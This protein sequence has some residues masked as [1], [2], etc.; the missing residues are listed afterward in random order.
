MATPTGTVVKVR[1]PRGVKEFTISD[2]RP[3][4]YYD[5]VTVAKNIK[6]QTLELFQKTGGSDVLRNIQMPGTI[7]AGWVFEL[8]EIRISAVG[9]AA[10]ADLDKILKNSVLSYLHSSDEIF[11]KPLY[12]FSTG[13][14]VYTPANSADVP[15]FGL[16]TQSAVAKLP[17]GI[18]IKGNE[19]MK[20]VLK[21]DFQFDAD[22]NGDFLSADTQIQVDLV[23]ILKKPAL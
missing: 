16:P 9:T 4:S 20:W 19:P 10:A 22:Q 21:V 3:Y 1:T 14:G 7:P 23:G 2:L 8:R 18:F 17:F 12:E 15:T 11:K 6:S 13:G 5:T